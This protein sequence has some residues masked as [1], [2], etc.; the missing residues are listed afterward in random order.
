MRLLEGQKIRFRQKLR[1]VY[2]KRNE[3]VANANCLIKKLDERGNNVQLQQDVANL[4]CRLEVQVKNFQ[5][6]QS[7]LL[8]VQQNE[9]E[10][11]AALVKML[12]IIL[13]KYHHLF[14]RRDLTTKTMESKYGE[15][16]H[17][18][19]GFKHVSWENDKNSYGI[20]N[21]TFSVAELSKQNLCSEGI[22]NAKAESEPADGSSPGSSCSSS[23][24][25]VTS[26]VPELSVGGDIN[27]LAYT[28]AY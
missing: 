18:V 25:T 24:S 4:Q 9:L 14:Q 23:V 6:E 5:L 26:Q 13:K 27:P 21:F 12:Y 20:C 16:V 28:V 19:E 15:L 3:C 8:S 22:I 11:E 1:E 10:S 2:I 7:A 17:T